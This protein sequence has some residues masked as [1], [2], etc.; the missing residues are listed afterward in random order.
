MQHESLCYFCERYL[1][2]HV[3]AYLEFSEAYKIIVISDLYLKHQD[4]LDYITIIRKG[5]GVLN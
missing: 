5:T 1:T 4:I 2:V 3:D